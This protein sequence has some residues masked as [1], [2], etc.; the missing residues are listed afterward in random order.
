MNNALVQGG[1]NSVVVPGFNDNDELYHHGIKGQKWGVRRYTNLDG[2]LTEE[3][4]L[5]YRG[6]LAGSNNPTN[7]GFARRLLVGDYPL[8]SKRLADRRE[9]RLERKI[10]KKSA[11]GEDTS[12]LEKKYNAQRQMNIDR[13][14]Y[15]SKQSTGKLFLQNLLTVDANAYRTAKAADASDGQ[16]FVEQIGGLMAFAYIPAIANVARTKDKYGAN[17]W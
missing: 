3:G 15:L 12:K 8:G 9:A 10:A 2:T 17:A 11:Q 14:I 1:G 4:I 13:D 7:K 6:G 16:A 5:R